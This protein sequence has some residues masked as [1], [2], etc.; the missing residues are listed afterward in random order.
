MATELKIFP[1]TSHKV[2]ALQIVHVALS[3]MP[4]QKVPKL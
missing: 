4:L 1:V 3:S 2:K